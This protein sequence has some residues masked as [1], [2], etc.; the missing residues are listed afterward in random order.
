MQLNQF[1]AV[2]ALARLC[3][4]TGT[5]QEI[6]DKFSELYKKEIPQDEEPAKVEARR[7]PY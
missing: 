6:Y 1:A 3:D 4:V 2:V 5:S 7:R